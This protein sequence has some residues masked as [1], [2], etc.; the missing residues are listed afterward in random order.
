RNHD[1]LAHARCIEIGDRAALHEAIGQMIGDVAHPG[2]AQ[3]FQ[4][5][6]QLRADAVEALGLGE[7]RVER[8]GAHDAVKLAWR[9]VK[10]GTSTDVATWTGKGPRKPRPGETSHA[11]ARVY[12]R[13]RAAQARSPRSRGPV[14]EVPEGQR[15]RQEVADRAADLQRA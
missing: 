9:I 11:S 4:R 8:L 7:Q 3:L 10:R 14:R 6:A 1:L 12:R 15:Y 13:H 5:L 2:E